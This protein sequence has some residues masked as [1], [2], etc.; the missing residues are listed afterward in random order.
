MYFLLF[1]AEIFY[2]RSCETIGHIWISAT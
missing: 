2:F 1:S